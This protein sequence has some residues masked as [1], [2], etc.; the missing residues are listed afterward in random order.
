MMDLTEAKNAAFKAYD[1]AKSTM[2]AELKQ[3]AEAIREKH[4][5]GIMALYQAFTDADTA[6]KQ[7]KSEIA[8]HPMEGRKVWK[9]EHSGW[10]GRSKARIY[11]VLEV[12]R[13]DT[14]FPGNASDY[15]IPVIGSLFVRLLNKNGQPGKKFKNINFHISDELGG[16]ELVEGD[17]A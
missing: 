1:S 13:L 3:A 2:E 15:N 9:T 7:Y 11:G 10:M 8:A 5:D 4:K 6:L 14:A 17:K 16:W 12:C